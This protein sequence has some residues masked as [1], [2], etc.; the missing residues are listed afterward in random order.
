MLN[1]ETGTAE[2]YTALTEFEFD[3]LSARYGFADGHAYQDTDTPQERILDTL[4]EL[5]RKAATSRQREVETDFANAS[6]GLANQ[7]SMIGSDNY[8][9]CTSASQSI[10]LACSWLSRNGMR[11]ALLEPTFDNLA[12]IVR[13][14]N[15]PITPIPE[16]D[17]LRRPFGELVDPGLIDAV[18]L[19]NPNNPT[20]S[21][22]SIDKAKEVI[23]WCVAHQKVMV[24]DFCFRYFDPSI[25]DFYELLISSGVKFIAIE[26]TGKTWSTMDMKA[27]IIAYSASL[28]SQIDDVFY[29]IFL[30]VSPFTL[31]VV[32]EFIEDTRLRG[33][34]GTLWKTVRHHRDL[35]REA[36]VGS[37]LSIEPKALHSTLALEWLRLDHPEMDDLK[38]TKYLA[39]YGV[40]CLP[41]RFFFWNSSDSR[42]HKNVRFSLLKPVRTVVQGLEMLKTA[43]Q[44]LK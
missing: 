40:A 14:W 38:F 2:G 7:V 23:S 16:A 9:V 6:F 17:L 43:L 22:L 10:D 37:V 24:W 44:D 12:L 36:I 19:V 1:Q 27:S 34:E 33:L 5:W 30:G 31:T 29:E 42:G 21:I 25:I 39:G 26:D 32:T 28:K 11:I 41:G 20:G 35:F 18:F 15:I 13:R 4:P 3:G 8:R